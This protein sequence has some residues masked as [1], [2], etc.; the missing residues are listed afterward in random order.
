MSPRKI[1]PP[2]PR[3][4]HSVTIGSPPCEGR[5]WCGLPPGHED[6][7]EGTYTWEQKWIACDDC[8]SPEEFR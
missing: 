8:K 6:D 3:C 7:H 4:G 2:P 5:A 1:A